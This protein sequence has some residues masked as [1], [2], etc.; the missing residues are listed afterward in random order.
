MAHSPNRRALLLAAVAAPFAF[1]LDARA[2]SGEDR[3]PSKT[4]LAAIEKQFGGRLGVYALDTGSGTEIRHRADERFPFCST[5]KM[6]LASAVLAKSVQEPG[7]MEQRMQ[8]AQ[9]DLVSYSPISRK[10]VAD[11]MTVAELC[12]AAVELSDNTAANQ[13]IKLLGG[14][15]A[16][17]AFA[18][19]IGDNTFRLDRWETELNTAIPG[20]PRDT[21]TSRAMAHTL[22]AVALGNALPET[23]RDTLQ[24]WL[25]GCQTGAKR[26]RAAVPAGWDVGDK[27]GTGDHGTANDVA[28]IWPPS[29]KPIVLAIYH[30]QEKPDTR[31]RDEA[32]ADAA[33]VVVAQL[34]RA[35]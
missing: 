18:R 30:T 5:F 16:V 32:I 17:T 31:G 20:D 15:A 7:L 21:T 19:S 8:Y 24:T 1:A 11:G 28:V 4:K 2:M 14:P 34:Q 6:V 35:S 29:R 23:Q 25:R 22:Q 13:L 33:R 3:E 27:T 9:S 26:I 10:H 12:R